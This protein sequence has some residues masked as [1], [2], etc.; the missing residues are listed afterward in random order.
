MRTCAGCKSPLARSE[1]SKNQWAK[2][3]GASKCK[4]CASGPERAAADTQTAVNGGAGQTASSTSASAGNSSGGAAAAAAAPKQV[5]ASCGTAGDSLKLCTGCRNVYYCGRDCQLAH[6]KA[7]KKQCK[8]ME[9]ERLVERLAESLPFGVQPEPEARLRG[10]AKVGNRQPSSTPSKFLDLDLLPLDL[11]KR[12]VTLVGKGDMEEAAWNFLLGLYM[13]FSL[14]GNPMTPVIKAVGGCNAN[15]PVAMALSIT[16]WQ[17][18]NRYNFTRERHLGFVENTC[19]RLESTAS[20]DASATSPAISSI[21]EVNRN[22]LAVGAAKLFYARILSRHYIVRNPFDAHNRAFKAAH[23]KSA[24]I[25]NTAKTNID[26]DRWLT[27]Q[28]ELGYSSF[29]TANLRKA[30]QWLSMVIK[31]LKK[32]QRE[33]GAVLNDHWLDTRASAEQKLKMV[34]MMEQAK[35]SGML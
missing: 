35:R 10:P 8:E 34:P 28:Y 25:I 2:G 11:W 14:D 1:Y 13:D 3:S 16:T 9:Q 26:P 22:A 18:Q 31:S 5:C 30:K 6:R 32:E 24:D 33:R 23:Q 27:L 17:S 12:G 7:H 15:D 20:A 4:A 19:K 29:D 21:D